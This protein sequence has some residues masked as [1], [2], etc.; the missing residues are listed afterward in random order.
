MTRTSNR[1]RALSVLLSLALI[2]SMFAS[3]GLT[4]SASAN[5]TGDGT[6]G[7][8]YQINDL[9]DL[10]ALAYDVSIGLEH[11]GDYFLQMH[12]IAAGNWSGI[13]TPTITLDAIT[14][15]PVVIDGYGFAGNYN[16]GGHVITVGR[17]QN[18]SGVGGVFNY[19]APAGVVH[20]LEVF[21]TVT[22]GDSF[23]CDAIGGVVGY[24][25]GTIDHV[26][27]R[28][29][30]M[31]PLGFNVGGIAGFNDH[32]Y[33][34]GAIGIISNSENH[35]TVVGQSIVGGIAGENAGTIASCWNNGDITSVRVGRSG[36]G[37]ITGRNGN[38]GSP[39][40]TGVI[41]NCYNNGNIS[42]GLTIAETGSWVGGIAGF[43]NALST[44]T[45]AY[46]TGDLRGFA[47]IDQIAGRT[48]LTANVINSYGM[49]EASGWDGNDGAIL[50]TNAVMHTNL[51]LNALQGTTVGIWAQFPAARP[52]LQYAES[53]APSPAPPR[54]PIHEVYLDVTE[55]MDGTG[56]MANPFN[57][58]TSAIAGAGVGGTIR[59]M[60]T[61]PLGSG[62]RNENVIYARAAGF[63]D[64]MF[65]INA[66]T[67]PG[68]T[69]TSM[70]ING[71]GVGTVFNVNLGRLRL[72][73]AI[74]IINAA[75]VAEVGVNGELEINRARI[76]TIT[77]GYAVRIDARP[78]PAPTGQ[79]I[80]DDFGF[81]DNY[82]NGTI[83]L[84]T[85]TH[86]Q[87]L[88][89][90]RSPIYIQSQTI[91]PDDG[92]LVA[93]A[94]TLPIAAASDPYIRYFNASA[95][96]NRAVGTLDYIAEEI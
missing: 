11:Q 18:A 30:V 42:G 52:H 61:V 33:R 34:V 81:I 16:G 27:S 36:A 65:E 13:G 2:L 8:P 5:W 88:S 71:G 35:N 64:V 82:M 38:N 59:L 96:I 91:D 24:N 37:G 43:Q 47:F 26:T 45:N 85:N 46:N 15:S 50:V 56:T 6:I 54:P 21:G 25:S 62:Q 19:V 77:G 95:T 80:L 9:A 60:A 70:T 78:A 55:P 12:P 4:A 14:N 23:Q 7:N 10:E 68:T 92:T 53:V 89:Q 84:G 28:V 93:S 51:F 87:L 17:S 72:R 22:V 31:A 49:F 66:F 48:E 67:A 63:T 74:S 44:I 58:L 29:I 94:N 90:V 57:N 83:Y 79:L 76:E 20:H 69:L 40:E 39:V 86:I 3:L 1:Q 41:R 73:G 75:T 32:F